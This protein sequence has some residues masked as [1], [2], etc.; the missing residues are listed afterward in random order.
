MSKHR[1]QG[2]GR[3][4]RPFCSASFETSGQT[5]ICNMAAGHNEPNHR[6][7]GT[8]SATDEKGNGATVQ[9][10]FTWWVEPVRV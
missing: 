2:K 5:W 6:E 10:E 9:Y 7:R 3:T 8:E 4:P 1:S